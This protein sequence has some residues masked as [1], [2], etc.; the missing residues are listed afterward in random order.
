MT[1]RDASSVADFYGGRIRVRVGALLFDDEQAPSSVLLV[2]HEGIHTDEF[3]SPQ[4][5]WTPPGGGVEFGEALPEALR[6]EVE[7]ET[8][9][10]IRVGPLRYTLDFVRLPLHAVSFYFQCSVEGGNLVTGSDPELGD[11]Q[12]IRSSRFVA[13]DDLGSLT[14]Y[15]EGFAERLPTDANAGF[16][17][18]TQYLG[19]LL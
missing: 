2:E 13:F 18:G 10:I 1:S 6:R 16:P 7:E 12:L 19:T 8:G 4:P 11:D 9:L 3:G 17:E 5:F 14:L 15:P